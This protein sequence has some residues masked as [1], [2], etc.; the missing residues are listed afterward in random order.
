MSSKALKIIGMVAGGTA[1]AA[2]IAFLLGF[3]VQA[4]WNWLMPELFGLPQITYWQA[5]GLLVLGHLLLGGGPRF[6]HHHEAKDG[7]HKKL[8][9]KFSGCGGQEPVGTPSV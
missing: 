8:K 5:W 2:A 3:A 6:N 7:F 1:L 4:L 9:E